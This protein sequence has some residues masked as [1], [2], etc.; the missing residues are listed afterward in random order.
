MPMANNCGEHSS[1]I[2]KN[3]PSQSGILIV[4]RYS[5]QDTYIDVFLYLIPNYFADYSWSHDCFLCSMSLKIFLFLF[6]KSR[7]YIEGW[8]QGFTT[9]LQVAH[10]GNSRPAVRNIFSQVSWHCRSSTWPYKRTFHFFLAVGPISL[11]ALC[12]ISRLILFSRSTMR[13]N[14]KNLVP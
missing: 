7:C 3:L 6:F 5:Y 9:N 1:C 10:T 2:L 11:V 12:Q 13:R 8:G 4:K 14:V